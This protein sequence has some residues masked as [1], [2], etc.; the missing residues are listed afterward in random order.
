[1]TIAATV[2]ESVALPTAE[3]AGGE[4]RFLLRPMTW[5]GYLRLL[6][7]VGNAGPRMAYLDGMVELMAP[8]FLHE[9]L[10]YVLGRMVTDLVVGLQIPARGLRSSTFTKESL[11]RGVE[12]DECFYLTDLYRLTGQKKG[13]LDILP[14][15]DLVV[16]VEIT[17]SLLDKLRLYSGL[18]VPEI[19][20]YDGRQFTILLLG[21]DGNYLASERSRAFPWLPLA[22]FVQQLAAFDP[23]RETEW[24]IRFRDW[25]RDVVTPLYRA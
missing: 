13:N 10:S 11:E 18:G 16:E 21:A 14:P 23:T 20:R 12:P 8:D 15:P 25:V 3:P 1:M 9:D 19:W 5:Q 2:A 6:D 7:E 17:S 24:N 22:G 4:S